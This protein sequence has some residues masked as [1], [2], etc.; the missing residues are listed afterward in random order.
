MTLD[1]TPD[2]DA[3][4]DK[5]D[6]ARPRFFTEPVRNNYRSDTEGRPV[7]EDREFVTILVPGD[8]K[9]EWSGYVKE[10]HKRRW[11]REYASFKAGLE[12]P[13]EGTPL[14]EW[15]VITRSQV[16]ELRFA[17]ILT[18]EQLATLPDD[19]LNRSVSMGGYQLREKAKR[20]LDAQAGNSQTEALAAENDRQREI[21]ADM[22]R[23]YTALAESVAALT[24]QSQK[25]GEAA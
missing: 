8:R 14:K 25:P 11:P 6:N 1:D 12:T 2:F 3:G 4:A 19:A 24:A 20:W 13:V 17:H 9:T 21:I 5:G 22:E 10:E 7:F 23:K 18:V 15:A 16:E